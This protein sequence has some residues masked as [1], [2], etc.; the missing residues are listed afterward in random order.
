MSIPDSQRENFM[1]L[2]DNIFLQLKK[3]LGLQSTSPK[4]VER[5]CYCISIIMIMGILNYWP[6]CVEDIISFGKESL[7][8]AWVALTI[9][10]N[11]KNELETI[12]F[13]HELSLK[14]Y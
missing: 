13:A 6:S 14:V 5:L 12:D 10:G 7:E 9:L 8:N 4:T 1:Q 3:L 2:R 11:V